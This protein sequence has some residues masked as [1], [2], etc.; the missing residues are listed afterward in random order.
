MP[1][2]N[3]ASNLATNCASILSDAL[4]PEQ[5]LSGLAVVMDAKR[6][7]LSA[8]KIASW[9]GPTTITQS[10]P[11]Y[12]A[13][14]VTDALFRGE[15]TAAFESHEYP[16]GDLS[17]WAQGE[18]FLVLKL[19]SDPPVSGAAVG[20]WR[21]N[22][23]GGTGGT[24]YPYVDGNIYDD[25]GVAQGARRTAGNPAP[26]LAAP[27]L[28]NVRS[29][30]SD[31]VCTVNGAALYST[32]VCTPTFPAT[33][34]FGRNSGTALSGRLAYAAFC[35]SVQSAPQ[36]AWMLAYLTARFGIA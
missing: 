13:S 19:T 5:M 34:I 15:P 32:A 9:L 4:T 27:H 2:D 23:A 16:L 30:P 29:A 25:F 20:L 12:Q 35:S 10:D 1:T 8:G 21:M 14:P 7:T 28:Y 26:S 33:A 11:T 36:R 31:W 17:A 18:A 6:V 24:C 3:A 22:G